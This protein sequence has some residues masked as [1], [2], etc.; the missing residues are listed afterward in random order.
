MVPRLRIRI[1]SAA[2]SILRAGHPWLFAESIRGQNREGKLGEL[3]VVFDRQDQFLA[4]GL[5]DPESPIRVRVLHAGKP[6]VLDRDWWA[7]RLSAALKKRHGLFDAAT[8]GYRWINGESDGWPGLVLDR[9]DRTV[10]LKLYSAAWLPRLDDLAGL[11][12]ERLQRRRP[13]LHVRRRDSFTRTSVI[14]A[15]IFPG[16]RPQF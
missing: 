12:E 7:E 16:E 1:S 14:L 3:A 10:V 13:E 2:E 15:N 8:T 4:I 5:F 9:Y 6:Q 11:I